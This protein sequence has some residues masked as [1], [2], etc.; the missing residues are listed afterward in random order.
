[1][2][3]KYEDVVQIIHLRTSSQKNSIY[4]QFLLDADF[5]DDGTANDL[6]CIIY[7][8]RTNSDICFSVNEFLNYSI[9]LVC[10]VVEHS[11]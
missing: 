11:V 6:P 2:E 10:G 1:M 9:P 4:L 8:H 7:C 3:R 5:S